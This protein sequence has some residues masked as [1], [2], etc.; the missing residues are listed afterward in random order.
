MGTGMTGRIGYHEVDY[1]KP[2]TLPLG[3]LPGGIPVFRDNVG[4]AY[5]QAV[6]PPPQPP[7]LLSPDQMYASY[8]QISSDEFGLVTTETIPVSW[9]Y[10]PGPADF[11]TAQAN[12]YAAAVTAWNDRAAIVKQALDLMLAPLAKPKG[13]D[14]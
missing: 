14:K 2:E 11:N 8:A 3:Y 7:M 4:E 1:D 10:N 13:E 5:G 9:T 12:M 6:G